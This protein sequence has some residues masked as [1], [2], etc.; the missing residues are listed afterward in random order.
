M[1]DLGKQSTKITCGNCKRNISVTLN[2]VAIQALI[3][4]ICGHEIQLVD[5]NGSS[6]KAVNDIN[7]AFKDLQNT[8]KKFGR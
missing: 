6:R 1:I 7:K 8:F 4:C 5:K 2:Q 3:R